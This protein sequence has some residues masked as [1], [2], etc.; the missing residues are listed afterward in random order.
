MIS[1]TLS[2]ASAQV[3]IPLD[4]ENNVDLNRNYSLDASLFSTKNDGFVALYDML[5]PKGELNMKKNKSCIL[6]NKLKYLTN[7]T[8]LLHNSRNIL[9]KIKTYKYKLN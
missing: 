8:A 3:S 7:K 4:S 1:Q 6:L 2:Y 9:E 5:T